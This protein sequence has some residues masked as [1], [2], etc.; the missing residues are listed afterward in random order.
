M[1]DLD[2]KQQIL[3]IQGG[4]KI[5]ISI[6]NLHQQ[7]RQAFTES[8]K[9][10]W[11]K[12]DEE[13]NNLVFSGMGGS[14]FPAI[15]VKELFKEQIAKPIVINDN[16]QLPGFVGKKTLVILN[17]YSGTTEEVL[18]MAEQAKEKGAKIVGITK[19]G[20]LADFFKKNNLPHYCFNPIYNPS[21]QPR[22]GFGYS[23]GAVLGLLTNLK[24]IKIEPKI[25]DAALKKLELFIKNFSIET[26]T[27]INQ[28][29]K[30]ALSLYQKYPYFIVSEF[31]TGVGNAIA[32]QINETA[33]NISDFRV[34]PELNH[35]LMEGLKHP[36]EIK[37]F[38]VFV[39][40]NSEFF[41]LRIQKRVKIT[42]EIV[43]KNQIKT[44]N[45]SLKGKNKI[46][47]VFELM[48]LGSFLS[49]YLSVLYQENPS[50]VPYVDYFKK[51][52][53]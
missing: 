18:V 27:K 9:I 29:K 5:V 20:L 25:I 16:Y 48:A 6:N 31:L 2:N 13:I 34:I 42:N 24:L 52:I 22:I 47:Q 8:L 12:K 7:I 41:D 33:K 17:S 3:K 19:G 44:I 39:F 37:K 45:Y 46:E 32:N 35:H 38:L 23:V 53:G 28:A 26:P 50:V 15:I 14:R 51:K 4:E 30:L 10:N 43:E 11:L 40:F 21:D 1:I 49:M 36:K